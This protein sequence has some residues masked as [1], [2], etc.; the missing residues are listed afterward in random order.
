[1][2]SF[3]LCIFYDLKVKK[4]KKKDQWGKSLVNKVY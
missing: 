1:M 3:M 4:K 2:I